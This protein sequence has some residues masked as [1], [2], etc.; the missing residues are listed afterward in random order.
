MV[1]RF[2][3]WFLLFFYINFLRDEQ[4]DIKA[5]VTE[6]KEDIPVTVTLLQEI[7]GSIGTIPVTVREAGVYDRCLLENITVKFTNCQHIETCLNTFKK[8]MGDQLND[9]LTN[10]YIQDREVTFAGMGIRSV[11]LAYF[12][13]HKVEGNKSLMDTLNFIEKEVKEI[14]DLYYRMVDN[15]DID[16]MYMQYLDRRLEMLCRELQRYIDGIKTI[17]I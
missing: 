8:S 6:D 9:P 10:H 12:Q 3:N 5:E 1:T 15:P 13:T 17:G 16:S 14:I 11:M 2:I 7:L 4:S